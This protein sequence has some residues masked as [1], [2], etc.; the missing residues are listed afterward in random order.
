[1]YS[2]LRKLL[3]EKETD[4]RIEHKMSTQ[5]TL[6]RILVVGYTGETGKAL[7]NSLPKA[8]FTLDHATLCGRREI[9]L[10]E[11]LKSKTTQMKLDFENVPTVSQFCLN[12]GLHVLFYSCT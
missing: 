3:F 9:E 4:S 1:M 7:L 8:E 12:F 10:P 11:A 2:N 6:G 5:R